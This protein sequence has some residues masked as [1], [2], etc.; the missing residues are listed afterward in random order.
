MTAKLGTFPHSLFVHML[1]PAHNGE[2]HHHASAIC[3]FFNFYFATLRLI[4][5]YVV[6]GLSSH[7][8]TCMLVL[9]TQVI[10]II[11][12]PDHLVS[13]FIYFWTLCR[14]TLLLILIIVIPSNQWWPQ[15]LKNMA[16]LKILW[17]CLLFCLR[18]LWFYWQLF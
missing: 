6:K 7:S 8:V 14:F 12:I 4:F 13:N 10:D 1:V 5:F 11:T 18:L 3:F 15:Y 16:S 17:C 2:C 9:S